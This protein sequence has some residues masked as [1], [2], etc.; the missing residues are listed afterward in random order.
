MK[1]CLCNEN[2]H[3]SQH[4]LAFLLF[5]FFLSVNTL[6]AVPQHCHM[7]PFVCISKDLWRQRGHCADIVTAV[8]RQEISK[9]CAAKDTTKYAV[10]YQASLLLCDCFISHS[11]QLLQN[12]KNANNNSIHFPFTTYKSVSTEL[13]IDLP[14]HY[15]NK[16]VFRF[17]SIRF[18]TASWD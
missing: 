18:L 17:V 16:K 13:K 2:C 4:Q 12:R 6:L 7:D 3:I 1:H 5:L 15:S 8:Q 9:G 11:S 14:Y 10:S